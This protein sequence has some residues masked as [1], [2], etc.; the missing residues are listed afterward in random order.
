[1][2]LLLAAAMIAVI[3]TG[4]VAVDMVRR[5]E[6]TLNREANKWT[7]PSV[8]NSCSRTDCEGCGFRG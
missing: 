5:E 7:R 1:M 4:Y 3:L 6:E 2:I 8:C